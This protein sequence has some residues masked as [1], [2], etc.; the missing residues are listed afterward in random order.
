MIDAIERDEHIKNSNLDYVLSSKPEIRYCGKYFALIF[1]FASLPRRLLGEFTC[2]APFVCNRVQCIER[3]IVEHQLVQI[4]LAAVAFSNWTSKWRATTPP[5]RWTCLSWAC[6]FRAVAIVLVFNYAH[7]GSTHSTKC[8]EMVCI[9]SADLLGFRKWEMNLARVNR[10]LNW[11]HETSG[12]SINIQSLF[13]EGA[14]P[15]VAGR[16]TVLITKSLAQ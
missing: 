2:H 10:A 12:H 15:I 5:M 8:A 16:S 9:I 4:T 3:K 7:D 14:F 1:S 11:V 13:S 6:A